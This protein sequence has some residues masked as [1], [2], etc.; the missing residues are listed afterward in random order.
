MVDDN[1]IDAATAIEYIYHGLR[2]WNKQEI[3]AGFADAPDPLAVARAYHTETPS[4]RKFV[5]LDGL[6]IAVGGC[7]PVDR[8]FGRLY[9]VGRPELEEYGALVV[10][11]LRKFLEEIAYVHGVRTLESWAMAGNPKSPRWFAALGGTL[12]RIE[13]DRF[14]NYFEVYVWRFL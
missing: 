6:P 7:F 9:L 4:I 11:L 8:G 12:N 2:D 10:R 3:C 5:Y 1:Q 13:R 14:G